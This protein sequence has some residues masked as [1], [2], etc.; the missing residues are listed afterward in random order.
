MKAMIMA[1][2]VGSRLMPLTANIPKPMI[3]MGNRPLMESI[4]DLLKE[5][6]FKD[7]IANLHYHASMI[8]NHFGD[9]E[10]FGVSMHYSEEEELM[11]TAGGVKRCAWFLDDTFVVVSGDALTDIDL[12]RLLNEHQKRGA[13]A[14]IAIKEVEEVERFG[15]VIT[16]GDGRIRSFQEKPKKEEALSHYANTGIYIF[17]PEIFKYI[18]E[19]EFYDFGKQVFP[20]LVNIK[21]PFYAVPVDDYWCDVGNIETYHKA[22]IDVLEGKVKIKVNGNI[23]N[24][25]RGRI[26]AGRETFL[27]PEARISGTSIIGDG[28][29]IEA[30]AV[31]HNA[32]IWDGNVVEKNMVL[33]DCVLGHGCLIDCRDLVGK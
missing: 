19:N 28:C 15:V 3:P 29:R 23:I 31:V 14:T 11:G 6:G 18:P 17:E 13:L 22:N 10:N 25:G 9:G 8:L 5:H 12:T 24:T 30:G 32:V 2:G 1:A 4:V 21:A 26:L 20:H 33:K 7:I 16:D 27:D